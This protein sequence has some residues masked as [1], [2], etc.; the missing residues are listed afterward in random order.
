MLRATRRGSTSFLGQGVRRV[1]LREGEGGKGEG[2]LRATVG[3]RSGHQG[4]AGKEQTEICDKLSHDDG[5]QRRSEPNKN[6]KQKLQWKKNFVE[7]VAKF[8][9][10]A[11]QTI[12]TKVM[13]M[14]LHGCHCAGGV[15]VRGV[16]GGG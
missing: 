6:K 11:N 9:F 7:F 15:G 12:Y 3:G 13:W 5:A 16:N 1:G 14:L 8:I 2:L 4:R 10:E